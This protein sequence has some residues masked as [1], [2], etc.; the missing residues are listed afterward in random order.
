M[1]SIRLF[2]IFLFYLPRG[3][4]SPKECIIQGAMPLVLR[5]RGYRLFF[6]S[7][8]EKE[9]MHVHVEK[10]D[11]YCKFWLRPIVLA[12][13]SGFKAYE[14]SDIRRVIEK[15]KG[16]IEE[17]WNAHSRFRRRRTSK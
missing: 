11:N 4:R 13:S 6:F 16:I 10:D 7:G 15:N 8:D 9:P 2:L 5:E 3:T 1:T 17:K 12:S 14:L